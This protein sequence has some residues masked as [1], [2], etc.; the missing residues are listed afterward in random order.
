M[1]NTDAALR[2]F[3]APRQSSRLSEKGSTGLPMDARRLQINGFCNS[4]TPCPALTG[5]F[6]SRLSQPSVARVKRQGKPVLYFR[7]RTKLL[8]YP[9]IHECWSALGS[10][11]VRYNKREPER[12]TE[13]PLHPPVCVPPSV[14][15]QQAARARNRD[16]ANASLISASSSKIPLS[17]FHLLVFNP[18]NLL[19]IP[20]YCRYI[21]HRTNHTYMQ[22]S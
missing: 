9:G 14:S 17:T 11:L 7:P 19:L 15:G 4:S 6:R 8:G 16:R 18:E 21:K 20:M 13:H 5:L 22:C 3:G 10:L 12:D 2:S 1:C